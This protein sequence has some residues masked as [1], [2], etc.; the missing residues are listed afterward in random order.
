MYIYNDLRKSKSYGLKKLAALIDPDKSKTK[1]LKEL[2]EYASDF[3]IDYLFIG[4][5]FVSE[6]IFNELIDFLR[7][8]NLQIPIVLFPGSMN[9]LSNKVDALLLLTLISGR[10]PDYLIGEHVKASNKIKNLNIEII[11]TGYILMDS[12]NYT[13]AQYITNTFPIPSN[14]PELVLA[15]AL[16]GFQLGLKIIYLDGG[17]GAKYHPNINAIKSVSKQI[18]IPLIVGGGIYNTAALKSIYQAGADIAV[19]GTA[20]ESNPKLI[21]EFVKIRNLDYKGV[22]Q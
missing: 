2:C 15:T 11:P 10:N 9:Q 18:E 4:G 16:A 8:Q 3:N 21:K 13:T 6:D 12:G 1:N 7:F 14:K 19:I 20:F 17:S 22:V 5:S